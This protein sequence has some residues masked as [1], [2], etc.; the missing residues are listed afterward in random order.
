MTRWY[1]GE[2][3]AASDRLVLT[4]L[5]FP[6]ARP[7]YDSPVPR[8]SQSSRRYSP[9]GRHVPRGSTSLRARSPHGATVLMGATPLRPLQTVP[10]VVMLQVVVVR[11]IHII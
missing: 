1:A 7:P 2:N 10:Q 4:A 6:W 11:I 9:H 5:Q 3:S 8:G